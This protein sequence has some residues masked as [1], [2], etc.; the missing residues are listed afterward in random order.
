M[1]SERMRIQQW[2]GLRFADPRAILERLAVWN[3]IVAATDLPPEVKALRTKK[4]RW[5]NEARQAALFA[6]AMKH[7]LNAD[8][9]EFAMQE[10]ADYDCVFRWVRDG[11]VH[12][13]P[14]QLKELVGDRWNPNAHAQEVIDR[15]LKYGDSRDLAVGI[16]LNRTDLS[17]AKSFRFP[18]ELKVGQIFAYGCCSP[19]GREWFVAGDWMK[20]E[21]SLVRFSYPMPPDAP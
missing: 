13:K 6:W 14:V 10:A 5:A 3:D 21:A 11:E 19:D 12:H 17:E 15:L 1:G 9:V 7:W 20:D 16:F 8:S 18:D 4:L 2:L